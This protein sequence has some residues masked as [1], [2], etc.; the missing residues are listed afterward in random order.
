MLSCGGVGW[1]CWVV[2]VG[3]FVVVGL[4]VVGSVEL[5]WSVCLQ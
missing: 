1:Q 3:L 4:C 2:M 5:Q